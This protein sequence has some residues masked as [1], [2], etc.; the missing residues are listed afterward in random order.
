M[1][2]TKQMRVCIAVAMVR[3]LNGQ[4]EG[5]K[6]N[7]FFY[8]G[9]WIVS[10]KK[11]RALEGA[12]IESVRQLK[13]TAKDYKNWVSG[14]RNEK[15]GI[16]F[17]KDPM[18]KLKS[19]GKK[20]LKALASAWPD[21]SHQLLNVGNFVKFTR[22]KGNLERLYNKLKESRDAPLAEGG[23]RAPGI[24]L[25]SLQ[26]WSEQAK[27]FK[28]GS[29]DSSKIVYHTKA[30]NPFESRYGETW[31]DK[32]AKY[33]ELKKYMDPRS[34]VLWLEEQRKEIFK[35]TAASEED[36]FW[37]HDALTILTDKEVQAWMREKGILRH[38]ILP[39]QGLNKGTRWA[40][41]PTGDS[42]KLMPMDNN[43]NK[44]VKTGLKFHAR[45]TAHAADKSVKYDLSTPPRL[46]D[47]IRRMYDVKHSYDADGKY[48][49]TK[50]C[51]SGK[52]IVQDV[53]RWLGA[54]VEIIEAKGCVVAGAARSGR[55][56][57]LSRGTQERG[58]HRE[59]G[60]GLDQQWLAPEA[61]A[62]FDEFTMDVD[63]RQA[64]RVAL[65]AEALAAQV[66]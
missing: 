54:L 4:V 9:K 64:K 55:R 42:P 43:L 40:N 39:E 51:P 27:E 31:R 41:S 33:G 37:Y 17:E 19:I 66:S 3:L 24:T 11:W 6:T 5:R 35:G 52:R 34:L 25:E 65:K 8:T 60:P 26:A 63:I 7:V 49:E 13:A 20:K 59:K 29:F 50:G 2:Y 58:G 46:D 1:K 12:A 16:F 28:K 47:A 57:A 30:E 38:W 21:V 62:C 32:I 22:R 18:S 36:T 15:D 14:A 48:D 23:K 44:D 53:T 10:L 61:R 56:Q 45:A